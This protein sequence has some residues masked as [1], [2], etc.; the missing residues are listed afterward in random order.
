ML[1]KDY[2][3]SHG[4]GD[5]Y[6]RPDGEMARIDAHGFFAVFEPFQ[7]KF[8]DSLPIIPFVK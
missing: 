2:L 6:L 8:R 1:F 5:E 7:T 3:K 4:V